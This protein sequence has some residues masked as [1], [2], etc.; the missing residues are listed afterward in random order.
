MTDR[1]PALIVD[2]E[3][4]ARAGLRRMLAE[5]T[6]LD[7]VG[8]AAN[9]IEAREAIDRLRPEL[10]FLDIEMPGL[11]GLDLLRALAG[12]PYVVFTTAYAE[13]AVAAFEL[14]AI[15]Y[16]LKPFGTDRLRAC[17]ERVRAA[18]G[19]PAAMIDRLGEALSRGPISRLFVRTGRSIVPVAI[20]S[21]TRFEAVGDYVAVHCGTTQHLLH[22]ALGRI[23]ERVDS[24]RFVRI[25]RAHLVNLDRV[26]AFRRQLNGQVVAE[27]DDGRRLPVSRS[28]AQEL[29]EL[30][31]F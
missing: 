1:V 11:N 20:E 15:D 18:I 3:P 16:L 10:V 29:R 13:H 19:E 24:R 14:G 9:G 8:E 5:E 6:W 4:I 25:H 26:A 21:I 31:R 28:K 7:C 12:P 23:E 2:D 22:L 30:T 27:L 17:L